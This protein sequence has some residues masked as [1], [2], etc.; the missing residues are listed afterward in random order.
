V[1]LFAASRLFSV[2]NAWLSQRLDGARIALR[3]DSVSSIYAATLAGVGI[4]LLPRAV[5]D[6]DEHLIRLETVSAP[7]PRS[8]WQA[9]HLDL[10]R[11]A[12]VQAVLAFL[13][14]V[15]AGHGA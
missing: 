14:E 10:Q 7:E 2:E 12:R 1:L 5:A 6:T 11:S 9:V 4:A 15:L 13:D 8:I 3:S